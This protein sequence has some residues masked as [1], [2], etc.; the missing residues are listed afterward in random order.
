MEATCDWLIFLRFL[1]I[2][3]PLSPSFHK[4]KQSYMLILLDLKCMPL[5]GV[6]RVFIHM[7]QLETCFMSKYTPEPSGVPAHCSSW[8]RL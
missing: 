8:R 1:P 5:K 4:H 7:A 3:A 6:Q 2:G